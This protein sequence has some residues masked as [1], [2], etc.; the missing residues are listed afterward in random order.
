MKGAAMTILWFVT[1]AV[2]GWYL[3]AGLGVRLGRSAPALDP[4]PTLRANSEG[5]APGEGAGSSFPANLVRHLPTAVDLLAR[6]LVLYTV[7]AAAVVLLSGVLQRRRGRFLARSFVVV[8]FQPGREGAEKPAAFGEFLESLY[9]ALLVDH[10]FLGLS[11]HLAVTLLATEQGLEF[12]L[13]LPEIARRDFLAEVQAAVTAHYPGARVE[14]CADPLAAQLAA[15]PGETLIRERWQAAGDVAFP[16]RTFDTFKGDPLNRRLRAARVPPCGGVRCLG[17]QALVRAIPAGLEEDR[18]ARLARKLAARPAAPG[19]GRRANPGAYDPLRRNRL[20]AVEKRR[21]KERDHDLFEVALET[22]ALGR[23]AQEA[24]Q[25]LWNLDRSILADTTYR[26][27]GVFQG[28]RRVWRQAVPLRGRR[29]E[30]AAAAFLRRALPPRLP[31]LLPGVAGGRRT[32]LLTAPELTT[33]LHLPAPAQ[34]PVPRL[35]QQRATLL[36]APAAAYI[37]A[38]EEGERVAW[39]VGEE[40]YGAGGRVGPGTKDRTLGA[41]IAA[42]TGAGKSTVLQ[43][44]VLQDVAAGRGVATLDLKGG[45]NE[46]II[47]RLPQEA[48]ARVVVFDP[49]RC[50]RYVGL[51]PFDRRLVEVMG[52]EG[53]SSHLMGFLKK[54][55]GAN[56]SAATRVRSLLGSAI[57]LILELE[58]EPSLLHMYCFFLPESAYRDELVGRCEDPILRTFWGG[59]FDER[60]FAD[61]ITAVQTRL[62]EFLRNALVRAIL[63]QPR[64]TLD[65]P[66]LMREKGLLL[67]RLTTDEHGVGE[68]VQGLL[69]ALFLGQFL[70]AAL[71]R[72]GRAEAGNLYG[73]VLD[74]FQSVV[75]TGARDIQELFAKARAGG[76]MLVAAHQS[77]EQ[78]DGK[79]LNIILDNVPNVVLFQQTGPS[80]RFFAA[81]L[82]AFG[83]EDVLNL[84]PY[85]AYARF[86]VAGQSTGVFSMTTVRLPDAAGESHPAPDTGFTWPEEDALDR[87]VNELP[88]LPAKERVDRLTALPGEQF[89]AYQARRR[90]RDCA[91]R[92]FIRE[93]PGVD[94]TPLYPWAE[95]DRKV[96]RVYYLSELA[97]GTP[98]EEVEAEVRRFLRAHG[99]IGGAQQEQPL[100]AVEGTAGRVIPFPAG[101][102]TD[103]KVPRI[104]RKEVAQ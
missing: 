30:R 1:I 86:K 69:G 74:E 23:D 45:L 63:C 95:G 57:P 89:R 58:N 55:V 35:E 8:R 29:G 12:T 42:P 81:T 51:N 25:L 67:G 2:L 17:V 40:E 44:V 102:E 94:L 26:Q 103:R 6:G 92:A 11:H 90:K 49:A 21:G 78:L 99:V 76:L 48:E 52:V 9:P 24:G 62:R 80:A 82:Q 87:L 64:S 28:L 66:A 77:P 61:S 19:R 15:A 96:A 7:L 59:E 37:A 73:V 53:L 14:T 16:L 18:L 101:A 65:V 72:T 34:N 71:S 84:P 70:G 22:F 27:R 47:R 43:N 91:E 79:T 5:P 36:P 46:E 3:A 75:E 83:V 93:N 100:S 60:D 56:W 39:G 98:G 10:P 33:V 31:G 13:W 68:E 32:S 4:A 85:R 38:A 97:Y 20:A 88:R 50:R 54:L 104:R 41:Y